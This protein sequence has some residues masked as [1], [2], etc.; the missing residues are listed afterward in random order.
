MRRSLALIGGFVIVIA[1]YVF[2]VA[3]L[4]DK[5]AQL[6]ERLETDYMA[7]KKYEKFIRSTEKAEIQLKDALKELEDMEKNIIQETDVSLAFAKLQLKIQDL[8]DS[9]GLQIKSIKPLPVVNYKGY[10]GLPIYMDGIGNISQLG[11]FLKLLDSTKE[12]INIERLH[13]T[14]TPKNTLRIKMQLSG[15]MKT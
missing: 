13:V 14:T 9:S 4:S 5:R 11:E 10:T 2:F 15:L 6:K 12:F 7:L 1:V 3:P 8:A